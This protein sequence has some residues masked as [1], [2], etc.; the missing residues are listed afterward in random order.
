M[1]ACAKKKLPKHRPP[2][3]P[4]K[5]P[6]IQSR[7]KRKAHLIR[8]SILDPLPAPAIYTCPAL[9]SSAPVP[10][11]MPL[12][13][14]RVAISFKIG[15]SMRSLVARHAIPIRACTSP[16]LETLSALLMHRSRRTCLTTSSLL[17]SRKKLANGFHAYLRIRLINLT[18]SFSCPPRKPPPPL[19]AAPPPPLLMF[20][21]AVDLLA[22]AIIRRKAIGQLLHLPPAGFGLCLSGALHP[23]PHPHLRIRYV[24][25]PTAHT[26]PFPLSWCLRGQHEH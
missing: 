14:R 10:A 17:H 21:R 19:F 18:L 20:H 22:R 12:W 24:T 8:D 25:P 7:S 3:P 1:V 23:S 13:T 5:F 16:V 4:R 26:S 15:D 6:A 9:E 11:R 2:P